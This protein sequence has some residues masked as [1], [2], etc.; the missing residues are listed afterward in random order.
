MGCGGG[1]GGG[2]DRG[3][4]GYLCVMEGGAWA[5]NASGPLREKEA[6]FVHAGGLI[7][8]HGTCRWP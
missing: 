8:T 5:I 3:G 7:Y 6:F 4:A 1:R 2:T